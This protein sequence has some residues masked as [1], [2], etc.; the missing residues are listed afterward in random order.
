[1]RASHREQSEASFTDV[2]DD[3]VTL[4]LLGL[5]PYT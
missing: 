4:P 2:Q 5:A 1:M 3:T